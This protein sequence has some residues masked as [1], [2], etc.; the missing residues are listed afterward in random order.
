VSDTTTSN[1]TRP[2]MR[3]WL[4]AAGVYNIVW[5]SVVVVAPDFPFA[6]ANMPALAQPGRA[7]WQCLGMV[8]AAYGL[9]Y[10]AA[11]RAPLRHWPIVFV[12]LFGK[13]MGPIGFVWSAWH[14]TIAWKFGATIL[15]N[16]LLWWI[17]FGLMLL[18]ARRA[19]LA[20]QR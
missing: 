2:W 4:L 8:L 16:D 17:P 20:S 11:S 18:A 5:G 15:T 13:V 19:W 3:W 6:L 9:G 1:F 14:G 10:I 12:G 7:I